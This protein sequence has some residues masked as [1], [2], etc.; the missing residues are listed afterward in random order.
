MSPFHTTGWKCFVENW[1]CTTFPQEID[2][3]SAPIGHECELVVS[4]GGWVGWPSLWYGGVCVGSICAGRARG[5]W[6]VSRLG[7]VAFVGFLGFSGQ[8]AL[9]F[10]VQKKKEKNYVNLTINSLTKSLRRV[11][12][13]THD[14]SSGLHL[15]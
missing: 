13:M 6:V 11:M 9:C 14:R 15:F 7:G 5:P 12:N 8:G 4:L 3:D 10:V 1:A 2:W